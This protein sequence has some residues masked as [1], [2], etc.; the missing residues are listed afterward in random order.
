[1]NPIKILNPQRN[2]MPL[3]DAKWHDSPIGYFL[4]KGLGRKISL[5]SQMHA[6]RHSL[7]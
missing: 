2:E 1:M 4:A 6:S 3:R 7:R 5:L